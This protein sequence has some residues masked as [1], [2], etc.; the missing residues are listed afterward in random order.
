MSW[1]N[2]VKLIGR[3]VRAAKLTGTAVK[4]TVAVNRPK[5][6]NQED[7]IADYIPCTAFGKNADMASSLKK[8]EEVYVEGSFSVGSYV[9]KEGN[10]VYTYEVFASIIKRFER[11]Q[12]QPQ[13]TYNQQTTTNSY[14]HQNAPQP[15]YNVPVDDKAFDLNIADDD[16]P[17]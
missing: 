16:L 15:Q 13:Q 4:F 9:N 17:F 12:N 3:I 5:Q 10:N 6:P 8:G 14:Q 7:S 2:S 11:H 1:N